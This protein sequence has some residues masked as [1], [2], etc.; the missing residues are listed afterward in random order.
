MIIKKGIPKDM[1]KNKNNAIFHT[2]KKKLFL[3]KYITSSKILK[4][5]VGK[6]M[7][8]YS[9]RFKMVRSKDKERM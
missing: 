8:Y 5:S 2:S 1:L 3:F 4:N 6:S 9:L 7:K